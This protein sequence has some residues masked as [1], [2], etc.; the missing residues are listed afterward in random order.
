VCWN[1]ELELGEGGVFFSHMKSATQ[2][3]ESQGNDFFVQIIFSSDYKD[4]TYHL[5]QN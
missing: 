3:V 2:C 5:T 1:I 4:A